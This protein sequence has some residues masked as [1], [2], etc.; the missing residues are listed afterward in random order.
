MLKFTVIALWSICC[1]GMNLGAKRFAMELVTDEGVGRMVL[2]TF[3]SP[4]FYLFLIAAIGTA[5][6]YMWLLRLM[7]L[8]IAG[9]IVSAL[10]V[11][12]VVLTGAV[13]L[14]E[15]VMGVKQMIGVVLTLA[16]LFLLQS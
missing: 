13:F 8:S 14:K 4:W 12:L 10:G 2:T 7:P 16:G 5:I 6:F 9:S 11:V 15:Q 1:I 3:R